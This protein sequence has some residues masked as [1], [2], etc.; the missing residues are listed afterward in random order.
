MDLNDLTFDN[1]GV[2]PWAA[3]ILVVVL[4]VAI[5]FGIGIM[6][7]VKPQFSQLYQARQEE[8]DLRFTFKAKAEMAGNLDKYKEQVATMETMFNTLLH[9]LPSRSEMPNLIEDISK[10]GVANGLEFKLIK[11][12]P[13]ENLEFYVEMPIEMSVIGDY[14][15]LAEFISAM[16]GLERIVTLNDFKIT[17]A[18]QGKR[19]E[20]RKIS[21]VGDL[22]MDIVA[23]TYRYLNVESDG[24][25]DAEQTT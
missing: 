1:I 19:G 10:L 14:H 23:K 8:N 13:E 21:K 15:Q 12:L 24:N 11:P 2:W 9:Q 3:K 6:F 20:Q 16:A 5:I 18:D 7:I 17:A 4:L 22:K 25:T